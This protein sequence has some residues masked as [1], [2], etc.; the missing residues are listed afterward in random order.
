M[1]ILLSLIACCTLGNQAYAAR[2]QPSNFQYGA[3]A[4]A[5]LR[6]GRAARLRPWPT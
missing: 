6:A 2:L 1:K 4:E 5:A 3:A